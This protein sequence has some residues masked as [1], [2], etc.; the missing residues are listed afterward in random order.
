MSA[1]AAST[2]NDSP[3]RQ[4]LGLLARAPLADLAARMQRLQAVCELPAHTWLRKPQTGM[5]MLRARIGGNG[6]QFNL[7]EATLTRCTLRLADGTVGVGTVRGRAAQHAE[8]I[9][10]CDALLQRPDSAAHVNSEVL[11]VLASAERARHAQRAA[12]VAASKVDFFTLV[13]GSD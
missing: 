3:R 1:Q 9:A 5:V 10:L 12:E 6:E 7:G 4:A 8:Y 11:D 13:R 2:E